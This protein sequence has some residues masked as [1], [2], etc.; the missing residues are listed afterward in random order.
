[1]YAHVGIIAEAA[2]TKCQ[3]RGGFRQRQPVSQL[4]RPEVGARCQL[5]CS[6]AGVRDSL[7]CW[8]LGP[9]L[10]WR[11][12]PWSSHGVLPA[13]THLCLNDNT[14]RHTGIHRH[15][16]FSNGTHPNNDTFTESSAKALFPNPFSLRESESLGGG[17]NNSTERDGKS[18]CEKI[19]QHP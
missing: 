17:G 7:F 9:S 6:F 15:G 1:M 2:G 12:L 18:A 19:L 8:P 16:T 4:P 5:S 13:C 11:P 14:I 3:E 10:A